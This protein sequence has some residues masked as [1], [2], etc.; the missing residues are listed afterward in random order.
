MPYAGKL[1]MA[2]L[3]YNPV[4]VGARLRL[5]RDAHE[6]SQSEFA[7]K[8]GIS[9]SALANWEQGQSRPSI[10]S[11]QCIATA[12]EL[13][14]DFIFLGRVE[15]L[16]HSVALHLNNSSNTRTISSSDTSSL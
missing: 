11:A 9:A 15:T 16:R 4:A 14:L 10:G 6:L 5:I 12:F 8:A 3:P 7:V 2:D 1:S 13:T